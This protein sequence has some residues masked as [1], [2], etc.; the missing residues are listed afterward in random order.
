MEECSCSFAPGEVNLKSLQGFHPPLGNFVKGENFSSYK[1]WGLLLLNRNYYKSL[2]RLSVLEL[3]TYIKWPYLFRPRSVPSGILCPDYLLVN[4]KGQVSI[5]CNFLT[6]F[7]YPSASFLD[8]TYEISARWFPKP[9]VIWLVVPNTFPF[10]A[11]VQLP[12]SSRCPIH[13]HCF[14][15]NLAPTDLDVPLFLD[16]KSILKKYLYRLVHSALGIHMGHW[17]G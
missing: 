12:Y 7:S 8:S 11:L 9:D 5:Q 2:N 15:L 13:L 6:I 1:L 17:W 14:L 10:Q 3:W 4:T 16:W